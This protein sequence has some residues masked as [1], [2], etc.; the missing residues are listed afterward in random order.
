MACVTERDGTL[1]I[2]VTTKSQNLT[3]ALFTFRA[4]D[5]DDDDDDDDRPCPHVKHALCHVRPRAM[6]SSILYTLLS[7]MVHLGDMPN[8]DNDDDDVNGN[9]DDDDDT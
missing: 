4:C 2:T 8:N 1:M 5:D 3:T 7:H 6:T 9:E